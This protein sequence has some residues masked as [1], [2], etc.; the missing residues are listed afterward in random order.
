M[1]TG[2]V[3]YLHEVTCQLR[4]SEG[5]AGAFLQCEVGDP[6]PHCELE[7]YRQMLEVQFL[8]AGL[9]D[10]TFARDTLNDRLIFVARI[11]MDEETAPQ[12]FARIVSQ[13]ALQ[14]REWQQNMLAG[15][16][17][18]YEREFDKMMAGMA[19]NAQPEAA[20]VQ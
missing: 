3:F 13:L 12:E 20:G 14:V 19:A 11:P 9:M 2:E 4:F 1:G 18:D 16:L 17:I 15:K 5:R 6:E 8:L 10:A 7:V